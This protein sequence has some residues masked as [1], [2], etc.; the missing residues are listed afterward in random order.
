[1]AAWLFLL[2]G[3]VAFFAGVFARAAA[4]C[5]AAT[6]MVVAA[7]KKVD[8]GPAVGLLYWEPLTLWLRAILK[9][10]SD[11]VSA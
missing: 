2:T 5:S 1:M 3:Y 10:A 11:S 6:G 4:L 7:A 8:G 9:R